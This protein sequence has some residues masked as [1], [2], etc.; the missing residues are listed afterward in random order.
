MMYLA[1]DPTE[2]D[3]KYRV[4]DVSEVR[5]YQ[6]VP[7]RIKIKSPR[8]LKYAKELVDKIMQDNGIVAKQKYEAVDYSVPYMDTETLIENGL[9]KTKE[10]AAKPF[11]QQ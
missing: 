8:T 10:T 1:L 7:S 6:T 5:R 9:I 11:Y 3:P 4:K 2:L